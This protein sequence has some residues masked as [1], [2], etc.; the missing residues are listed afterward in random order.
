M[1]I[2]I[3]GSTRDKDPLP[4]PPI[5]HAID[6]KHGLVLKMEAPMNH[7]PSKQEELVVLD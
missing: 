6:A 2:N 7:N 5:F 3:F 4:S 1:Y